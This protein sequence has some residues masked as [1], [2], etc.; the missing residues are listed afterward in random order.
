M[1]GQ[2]DTGLPGDFTACG[3]T[4]G[5]KAFVP[6]STRTNYAFCVGNRV[7]EL[8]VTMVASASQHFDPIQMNVNIIGANPSSTS[9]TN[10]MYALLT[11]DTVDM[12]ALRIKCT[13]F[14]VSIGENVKDAY[15]YQGE[16]DFVE[17]GITIGGEAAVLG[18]V[19][20]AGSDAVTGKVRGIIISM[21]GTGS[22][23]DTVGIEL[24]STATTQAEGIRISGTPQTTVGIAMGNQTNDN[25][26]PVNAF[27]FPSGPSADEGPVLH[28]AEAGTGAGSIKIKIGSSLKYLQ[29]WDNAS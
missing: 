29:Y 16:V 8:D 9:T 1:K 28:T 4:T 27:F 13:D 24:R 18:L 6:D 5:Y 14:N 25:E 17:A 7:T 12:A 20:N 23:A 22:P 19:M 15:C 26:G 10:L 21:Q 3:I 11:H 2:F